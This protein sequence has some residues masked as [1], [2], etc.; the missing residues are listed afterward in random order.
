M[1]LDLIRMKNLEMAKK[2]TAPVSSTAV[3]KPF[4]EFVLELHAPENIASARRML[5]YVCIDAVVAP[6][7]RNGQASESATRHFLAAY[8]T[9]FYGDDEFVLTDK[10][11]PDNQRLVQLSRAM[12]ERF[13][14]VLALFE[15]WRPAHEARLAFHAAA[16]AYLEY[17][18]A[19][20]PRDK[21]RM[22]VAAH[23]LLMFHFFQRTPDTAEEVALLRACLLRAGG[24]AA[25]EELD[26]AKENTRA[27][28]EGLGLAGLNNIQV[29][30]MGPHGMVIMADEPGQDAPLV[31]TEDPTVVVPEHKGARA[32]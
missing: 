18:R 13:E 6:D 11:L 5:E 30:S 26:R 32:A 1:F 2:Y 17:F 3:S 22:K 9:V 29:V 15:T 14:E 21:E 24:Q 4:E 31:F 23:Q 28:L 27:T 20:I 10:T 16:K 19:W 12:I 7:L 8:T 25:L